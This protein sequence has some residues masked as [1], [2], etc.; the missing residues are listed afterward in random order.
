M[1]ILP[2]FHSKHLHQYQLHTHNGILEQLN[3]ALLS[4]I[5][6]MASTHNTNK[7]KNTN[8]KYSIIINKY[9]I[10]LNI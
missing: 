6:K 10:Y 7:K 3:N 2:A 5:C 1:S 9:M 4:R 8:I